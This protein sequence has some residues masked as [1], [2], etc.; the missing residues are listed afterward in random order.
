MKL[1]RHGLRDLLVQPEA[2]DESRLR[3]AVVTLFAVGAVVFFRGEALRTGLVSL[4]TAAILLATLWACFHRLGWR[5]A[6]DLWPGTARG[7]TTALLVMCVSPPGL[8]WMLAVVMTAVA[9]LLEGRLRRLSVPLAL[10]GVMVAWVIGWAW[11]AHS[12]LGYVRP[13]DLRALDE[14][15]VLLSRAQVELDPV[16][17]YAGNVP[18][19]LGATSFGLL[20]GGFTIL[21]YCRRSSWTYLGGFALPIA[22][23]ALATRESLPVHLLAGPLV[24]FAGILGAESRRL[25]LARQWRLGA[26]L[27]G[28]V[29]AAVLQARGVGIESFGA[30]V[31]LAAGVLS[32]LQAFGMAGSPGIVSPHP[33]AAPTA[34]SDSREEGA[35]GNL[36]L[37]AELAAL[38]LFLPLG[39]ALVAGDGGLS[40]REKKSLV[41]VGGGLYAAAAVGA[42]AWVYAL[43]L[44]N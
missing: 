25:P 31:L 29:V 11:H 28:G 42:L 22:V 21:A 7:L 34:I 3:L 4:L 12:G 32:L 2:I 41:A 38:V 5:P 30:G 18:G 27:G 6:G 10:S 1:S 23:V 16:R 13:F 15:L 40:P 20:L 8:P 44:P 26:G 39:L 9:I 14:P 24:L 37:G 19:L 17:L 35:R 33:S 36:P 43:R